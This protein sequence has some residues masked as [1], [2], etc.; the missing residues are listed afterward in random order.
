MSVL[1][2]HPDVAIMAVHRPGADLSCDFRQK[3]IVTLPGSNFAHTH[4]AWD[5]SYCRLRV[6]HGEQLDI[7]CRRLTTV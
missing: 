6:S 2:T 7:L 3:G 1:P 4:A 5:D